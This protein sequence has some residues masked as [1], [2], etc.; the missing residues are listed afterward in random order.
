MAEVQ[1][2]QQ[3]DTF[4]KR[5]TTTVGG[6]ERANYAL[7]LTELCDLIGVERPNPAGAETEKNDYVFERAVRFRHDDGSTSPGRI[8]LYKRGCFV[9]EAKQSKKREEGGEV[10]EQLA[11]ALKNG[12]GAGTALLDR[13]RTVGKAKAT[14]LS[15]WDALMRSARKQAENY[16]KALEEWPPFLIVVDVGHVVELY[17]DFSCQGKNYAQFPDRNTF[18]IL[19][20][21]LRSVDIRE[22]L[23]RVW[24]DPFS[25]DPTKH[26]AEVTQDIAALL[27][28]M[29]QTMERRAPSEEPQI[30]AEWA[31]K[32]SKFLM[33]CIFAMFAE[34]IGLLPK[35]AFL[36]LVE[37]HKGK[38]KRFYIAAN[39]FF[40]TMDKGGYSPAIQEDI[41]KFNG[42]LF[43][44]SISV[45]I[46]EDELAL[47]EKAARR[48]WHA[49]EPAI[50]GT[51][52]EQA[53]SA[54]ERSQLGAH[55]TPRA[56]VERLVV[57]TIIEPLR[58]DWENV[59]S[60]AIG[61]LLD[62]NEKGAREAVKKFHDTLC[63]T[64]VLD[65][66]CGTGNF[67]Y[68]SMELMKRL[69]GEV[70]DFLKELGETTEPLRTVDPHQFLGIEL[71]PRAVPITELVLWIG[72]IQWWF[73]TR[74]RKVISEPILRDFGTVK[75]G[76]A[77]LSYDK[78]ELLKDAKGRPITR[79]DPNATKLHPITG[80]EI[81]DPDAKLPV[82]RYVNPRPAEWADAEFIV[83]NPPFIG[84]KDLRAEFGDGYTEALWASRGRKSDSIDFVMYW[85]DHGASLLSQKSSKLKR[86]GFITTNSITQ[87]FS[88]RVLDK[89]LRA[90]KP[91]SLVYAVPDHPWQKAAKKAAVRIAMTVAEKGEH[92][93]RLAEVVNERDLDTD[94]PKV[95]LVVNEGKILSDL[96]IG[97]DLGKATPLDA[98]SGICS[99]GMQLMGSG[100]IVTPAEAASLGLG[101][102]GDLEKHIRPYR[103]GR[104]LMDRSRGVMV[105]DLFE[106]SEAD[107]RQRFTAVYQRIVERVKPERDVN[108]RAS[109]RTQWWIFGEPRREIRPALEGLSRFIVT[110]ETMKHRV[111]QFLDSSIL[112]DNKLI[113]V[114][115]SDSYHLG[116]LCSN[117]HVTWAI[118]AGSWLGVGNDPVY[119]KQSC[120]DPFP[121]PIPSNS[122]RDHIRALADELDVLRRSVLGQ[123]EFLTMTKLYNVR[124]K[125]KSGEA[126]NEV[127]K[128]IHDAGCVGVIHELHNKID[129]AVADAYGWPADLQ[130]EAILA[131][132]VALNKERIAEEKQDAIRW[133]RPEYQAARAKTFVPKD[134]QLEAALE[135]PEMEAPT[136]PKDDAE[137]VATLRRALRVIGKPVEPKAIAA[138]FRREGAARSELKEAFSSLPPPESYVERR[139][140]GSFRSTVGGDLV[141]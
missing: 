122:Q 119:A 40:A 81:P 52:L 116:V 60:D 115:S 36:K 131:R 51:L 120:F 127:D 121:F 44:E 25:L 101:R 37:D 61:Q 107:V 79:Q 6:A 69:E 28:K 22:R 77:V 138:Q 14:P 3:V 114:A 7:F 130:N 43:H 123:H 15:K 16:A 141:R 110:V 100:F 46:N 38:A 76:D 129:T 41:K 9:L 45:E 75:Q 50:F 17:A 47:L 8:D 105:I 112:P 113:V 92:A 136:L 74:E 111:F 128:A 11:F 117:I 109:Y 78:Q 118:A 102:I 65:P 85:W 21:D 89:Y 97:A 34:D 55:Y 1:K 91:I 29:T 19:M 103:N 106:L 32:V 59:Q 57:P 64:R 18:R 99:R 108:N 35:G 68:V 2:N 63:D 71:N 30:K 66:A 90:D 134:E 87:K 137:L 5:W 49:V 126:L 82:Y 73:R 26:A 93:G 70:L 24:D 96:T 62:G 133:L 31:Y 95:E 56:F 23:R 54:R 4:I 58:E 27:A 12:Q 94:R 84:G 20:R 53:L 42:G 132:L 33:R 10:Y 80:E 139:Q 140:G 13:P 124:E 135:A 39:D 98:N 48:D 104:D 86:F 88:R 83:G 72:Y 67:L 125:L